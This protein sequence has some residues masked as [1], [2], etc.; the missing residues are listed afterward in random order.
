[1]KTRRQLYVA[2]RRAELT[3][4]QHNCKFMYW[5]PDECL[6]E[7]L[8]SNG[9]AAGTF[10]RAVEG[11]HFYWR[12]KAGGLREQIYFR[13]EKNRRKMGS[14]NVPEDTGGRFAVESGIHT[15]FPG[16]RRHKDAGSSGDLPVLG[17]GLWR[18]AYC[19]CPWQRKEE[20]PQPEIPGAVP[21]FSG[22]SDN[23]RLAYR[24]FSGAE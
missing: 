24:Q 8:L 3:W 12:D 6:W 20:K 17:T 15:K 9:K 18:T 19:F 2:A 14:K 1:M 21:A 11:N 22:T 5:I 16:N 4:S 13:L 7:S 23:L 10:R